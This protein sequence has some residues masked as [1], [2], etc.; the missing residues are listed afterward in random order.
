MAQS[1]AHLR[2]IQLHLSLAESMPPSVS[3]GLRTPHVWQMHA[4]AECNGSDRDEKSVGAQ[5]IS[6][7]CHRVRARLNSKARTEMG[8]ARSA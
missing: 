6:R 7:F 4:T 5:V 8:A 2:Q 1:L 3:F